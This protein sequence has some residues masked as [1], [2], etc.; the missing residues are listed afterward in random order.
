MDIVKRCWVE[1]DLNQIK[2]NYLIYKSYLLNNQQVMAV[3]KADAY[4]HGDVE[5]AHTLSDLGVENF[6]VSNI[7]EAEKIRKSGIKGQVLILG[8][9]P[10]ESI[11]R[12]F[13]N[14]ITQAVLSEE[15]ADMLVK[16][17][18]NVKCQ[19]AIDTGMNRIGIDADDPELCSQLIHKYSS[20]L[21]VTGLFTHLCT[22]DTDDSDSV[23][24]TE[25]QIGRF[26]DV[27]NQIRDLDLPY[28]HCL[29]SAG[30]LWHNRPEISNLVRLGIILY[31]LKPDFCNDLPD[32]IHPALCWKSVVSMVKTIKKGESVSYGR[33]FIADHDMRIATIPTGYADG[34]NRLLSNKG[35]VLINGQQANIV[36]RVCMD[37]FMVDV[38]NINNIQIGTEVILLG[39][40]GKLKIDADDMAQMIGSIGY[41]VVCDISKRVERKYIRGD[42]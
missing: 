9:T 26:I 41:E 3:V 10:E 40:S 27:K 21:T 30:G 19:F 38:S 23:K 25:K 36:G 34:Y 20:L 2:N 32:G 37:Q 7:Y 16:T 31:G 11:K 42:T 24:F 33:T 29:N 12:V 6:A 5:V 22:A 4:G 35:Y 8:Y 15:Y 17:G 14:D 18:I 13:E 39:S 1:I 28:I